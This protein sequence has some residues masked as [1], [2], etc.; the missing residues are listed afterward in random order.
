MIE[1]RDYRTEK[2]NRARLSL[3]LKRAAKSGIV[4]AASLVVG[5]LIA[6]HIASNIGAPIGSASQS[7]AFRVSNADDVVAQSDEVRFLGIPAGRIQSV[8]MQGSQPVVTA[9]F[10]TQYGHIYRNARAVVRPNTALEDMYVDVVY[11]GTPAAGLASI[12]HPLQVSQVDTSV[13]LDSV[14]NVFNTDARASLRSLLDNMGNGLSDRGASLRQGFVDAVP[15]IQVAGRLSQQLADR[16]VMVKRLVHNTAILTA[17]LGRN[18]NSLRQL[19]SSGS[20][21][22]TT[23]QSNSKPFNDTLA[24]LPG[25]L[26]DLHS[27]LAAVSGVLGRVDTAV[28]SLYPVANHLPASLNAVRALSASAS[29]AV[30]ALQ[31]PV[32][33]LVP[34]VRYLVPLSSNLSTAVG[35]LLPQVPVFN[36]A[37]G[38]LAQCRTGVQGFFQ[39][40]PSLAKYGDV[41]GQGPRGN[42][43]MGAQ[44]SGFLTDPFEQAEPACTPGMPAGGRATTAADNH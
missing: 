20:S 8:T 25:T 35:R 5:A 12:S 42:V 6:L 43:A 4:V 21:V 16:A 7:V 37:T 40:N 39:W 38:D 28:R 44:S 32:Q 11:P 36:K 1:V 34:L 41:R 33:K 27:S 3:E 13:N 29:P 22:L 31:A 9:A 19:I 2:I 10:Q 23:L 15:F 24:A 18:Q 17:D 26:T 30:N 14:L